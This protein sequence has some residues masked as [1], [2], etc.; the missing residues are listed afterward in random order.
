MGEGQERGLHEQFVNLQ[1]S[2]SSPFP[3]GRTHYFWNLGA[4][5]S[6]A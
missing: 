2:K 6:E 3:N 1:S 4:T 5:E